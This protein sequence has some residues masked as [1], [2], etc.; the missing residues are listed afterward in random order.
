MNLSKL[1][2][3]L[4]TVKSSKFERPDFTVI[5]AQVKYFL[6]KNSISSSLTRLSKLLIFLKK[7]SISMNP[8]M[9]TIRRRMT[10]YRKVTSHRKRTI[11]QKIS[12]IYLISTVPLCPSGQINSIVTWLKNNPNEPLI[13]SPRNYNHGAI[14]SKC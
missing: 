8:S 10:I 9:L 4:I 2:K 5:T 14:G 7:N 6:Q 13:N 1:E 3:V 12:T 11:S